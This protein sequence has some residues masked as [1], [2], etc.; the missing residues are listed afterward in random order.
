MLKR[1]QTGKSPRALRKNRKTRGEI[2]TT[3]DCN[4]YLTNL[5]KGRP[6][7]LSLGPL[8]R[9]IEV[10]EQSGYMSSKHRWPLIVSHLISLIVENLS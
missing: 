6:I 3:L 5:T 10:I 7:F 8:L 9:S 2:T 1:E 4:R